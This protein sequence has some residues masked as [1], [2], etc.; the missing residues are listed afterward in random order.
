MFD[1]GTII[2]T[3]LDIGLP[4]VAEI[5]LF[6]EKDEVISYQMGGH[7]VVIDGYA[8]P[9]ITPPTDEIGRAHV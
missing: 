8:Y 2:H 9:T 3:N 4:I 7:T 6:G 5:T 1:K